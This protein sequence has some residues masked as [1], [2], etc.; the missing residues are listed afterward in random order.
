MRKALAVGLKEFR[1]IRRDP[2]TLMILLFV[3]ALLLVLYGY[4]LNFD[5]RDI[6]LGVW[7]TLGI[8]LWTDLQ[9][10]VAEARQA[11]VLKADNGESLFDGPICFSPDLPVPYLVDLVRALRARP[12][13]TAQVNRADLFEQRMME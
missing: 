2:L 10:A 7:V 5:I 9:D 3:P 13:Y 4:A 12:G 8:N 11:G 6:P 1:Q